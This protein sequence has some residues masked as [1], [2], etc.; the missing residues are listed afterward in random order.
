MCRRTR[1]RSTLGGVDATGVR[2]RYLFRDSPDGHYVAV[3][4]FD[5]PRIVR[6][7][8]DSLT[9]AAGTPFRRRHRGT[10]RTLDRGDRRN[11]GP[12][13]RGRLAKTLRAACVPE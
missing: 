11:A 9:G 2:A 5:R 1:W 12:R 3:L 8:M 10:A 7:R 4:S 13:G 6:T